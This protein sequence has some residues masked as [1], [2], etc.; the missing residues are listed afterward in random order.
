MRRFLTV[1]AALVLVLALPAGG[2]AGR[3]Y[4]TS[5][6]TVGV[7][8]DGVTASSGTGFA[9]FS[10]Y[11]SDLYGPDAFLD[12]WLADQPSGQPDLNRD[13]ASPITATWNG[14]VLAGSIPM[15]RADGTS[16]GVATFSAELTPTGD[17]LT[18]NDRYKNRNRQVSFSGTSQALQ[19]TGSLTV[20][21][22]A[23]DLADCSG[24]ESTVTS[25][26]SN[27]NASVGRFSA[28]V[29]A[30]DLANAAGDTGFLFVDLGDEFGFIDAAITSPTG[31]ASIA[32]TTEF[33]PGTSPIEVDLALY[34]PQSG[35]PVAGT[36]HL[37]M[38]ATAT[39]ESFTNLLKNATARRLVRGQLIDIEGSLTIAGHVFD[40]GACVGEDSRT[41]VIETFPNGPK[42]GGKAPANDLPAGAIT[43]KQGGS[44]NIQ[45][46]GASPVA[47]APYE[48]L[49]FTDPETGE[50]V[51]IPVGHTVW[52]R[53][54]G[55]GLPMT[56]NTAGSDYDTVV[57]I[58]TGSVGAL[59]P[60]PDGCVDDSP[61]APVGRTLQASVTIPTI[62]GTTYFVQIGGFPETIPYGGLRVSLR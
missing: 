38:T 43:L 30:C 15:L 53:F 20:S 59:T 17:P 33:A 42:P 60:V 6:H 55:T 3:L 4:R 18:F 37:T 46:K 44:T 22:L 39:G 8:C 10:A 47:E 9:Y 27:P 32:A 28:R 14:S 13:W 24:D 1:I 41:K 40:L 25:T 56:I 23:F 16:A 61:V 2:S 7:S 62:A 26:E 11:I 48:C 29:V 35:E 52:Y 34:D 57:A 21:S 45:T 36:G 5:D 54:T 51:E 31:E 12:V 49:A 19:P 58:Y 50:V